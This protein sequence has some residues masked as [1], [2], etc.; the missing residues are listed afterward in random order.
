MIE[1]LSTVDDATLA[2]WAFGRPTNR[3]DAARA[4]RAAEELDR[5]SRARVPEP[6]RSAPDAALDT[7]VAN[8]G[9]PSASSRTAPEHGP[10]VQGA[11]AI[12][13]APPDAARRRPSTRLLAA[14]GLIVAVAIP[15]GV[16]IAPLLDPG[17][18][19]P[20]SLAVF[21]REFTDEEREYLR[22]LQQEGQRVNVGPRVVGDAEYGTILAYRSL[23]DDPGQPERDQVC[24]AVAEFD[25]ASRLPQINDWQCVDRSDF[26]AEG[27][28]LTLYGL[29]G[30][31]D[32][33]RGP[34]GR[35]NVDV[36]ITEAQRLAMD[37]GL[38]AVFLD[39]PAGEIEE[40]YVAAQP[41]FEQTGLSVEQLRG[42]FLVS[43]LTED[44]PGEDAG[45]RPPDAEW[46]V[47]YTA[48]DVD[49]ARNGERAQVACLAIVDDGVQLESQCAMIDDVSDRGIQLT[50]ERNARRV[51]VTWPTTGDISAFTAEQ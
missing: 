49:A 40:F 33:D 2:R 9:P 31:Y 6:P 15:A 26:E 18:A 12:D 27:A 38:E 16:A 41:L 39:I 20:S 3:A 4:Q 37:P 48:T 1:D 43:T 50:F 17:P 35:A 46:V 28:R 47:A 51:T 19:T 30:Q 22:L 29:G 34:T 32:V 8:D 5:R 7:V 24:L 11:G 10:E 13:E 21:D 23:R 42:V 44:E 25:R 14:V 45:L 36:L